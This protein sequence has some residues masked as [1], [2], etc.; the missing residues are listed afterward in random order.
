MFFDI[1]GAFDNAPYDKIEEALRKKGVENCLTMHGQR[2]LCRRI[3]GKFWGIQPKITKCIYTAVIR[4]CITYGALV[5]WHR[6][7]IRMFGDHGAMHTAPSAAMEILGIPSFETFIEELAR[8][9]FVL[10]WLITDEKFWQTPRK[11]EL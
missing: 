8:L 11:R 4:P 6:L 3:I 5:W 10:K 1:E 9:F 7:G 2:T